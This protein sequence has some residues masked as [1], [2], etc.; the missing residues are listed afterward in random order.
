MQELQR[1]YQDFRQYAAT[2]H[3]RGDSSSLK[4]LARRFSKDSKRTLERQGA[5]E[6]AA[7]AVPGADHEFAHLIESCR[8]FAPSSPEFDSSV[9]DLTWQAVL[10]FAPKSGCRSLQRFCNAVASWLQAGVVCRMVH[11]ARR[12]RGEPVERSQRA[13][14]RAAALQA[15]LAQTSAA[16]DASA[17][18]TDGASN[19]ADDP[20]ALAWPSASTGGHSNTVARDDGAPRAAVPPHRLIGAAAEDT[21]TADAAPADTEVVETDVDD[22]MDTEPPLATRPREPATPGARQQPAAGA[23]EHVGSGHTELAG[24][25]MAQSPHAMP[26]TQPD[27]PRTAEA[28]NQVGA[29]GTDTRNGVAGACE[30]V[31]DDAA[32]ADGDAGFWHDVGEAADSHA[33]ETMPRWSP[34]AENASPQ[35]AVGARMTSQ[36]TREHALGRDSSRALAQLP[37]SL[38]GATHA[39]PGSV[40]P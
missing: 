20:G 22:D 27:A 10:R 5:A 33:Y 24:D 36:S 29:V 32:V 8:R 2:A 16:P 12:Q 30:P 38:E 7:E 25:A 6:A 4:R 21:D 31:C 34:G 15:A 9:A 23:P 26:G 3:D 19:P 11:E 39:V 18:H 37:Q 40:R 14:L 13:H 28:G 17:P 1:R 35:A